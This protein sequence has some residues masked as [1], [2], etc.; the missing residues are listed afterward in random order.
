MSAP[1]MLF[2]IQIREISDASGSACP[3]EE[4]DKV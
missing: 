1:R 3:T 4:N 2:R